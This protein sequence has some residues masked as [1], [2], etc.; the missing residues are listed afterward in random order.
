MV[1]NFN[2]IHKSVSLKGKTEIINI[3]S[4]SEECSNSCHFIIFL[5]LDILLFFICLC[6]HLVR[7]IFFHIA[8]AM[9][10]FLF[11]TWGSLKDFSILLAICHNFFSFLIMEVFLYSFKIKDSLLVTVIQDSSYFLSWLEIHHVMPSCF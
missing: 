7:L 11:C 8:M 5:M 10:N 3:Q 4:Y 9:F 6:Y 1:L 2:P